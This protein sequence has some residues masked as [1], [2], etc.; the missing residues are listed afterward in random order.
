MA[1]DVFLNF[2]HCN[3]RIKQ[4]VKLNFSSYWIILN[5]RSR[6]LFDK[7]IVADLGDSPHFM[8]A[9]SIFITKFTRPNLYQVF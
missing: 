9:E 8:K 4:C 3:T 6:T 2:Y 5:L 1:K 7:L